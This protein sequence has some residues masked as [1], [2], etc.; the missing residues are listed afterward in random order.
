MHI[1]SFARTEEKYTILPDIWE[2]GTQLC[3]DNYHNETTEYVGSMDINLDCI[4][5][6]GR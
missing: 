2:A 4:W 6:F 5:K 1:S 3:R